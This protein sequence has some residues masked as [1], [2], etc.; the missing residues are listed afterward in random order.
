MKIKTIFFILIFVLNLFH[1]ACETSNHQPAF[2]VMAIAD[3]HLNHD[4]SDDVNRFR[5]LIDRLNTGEIP[6][7]ELLLISGDLVTSLPHENPDYYTDTPDNPASLFKSII[8]ELSIPYLYSLGNHDYYIGAPYE[9]IHEYSD[10]LKMEAIWKKV[11]DLDPPYQSMVYNGF[12][13]IA[14]N[15]IRGEQWDYFCFGKGLELCVGSFDEQQMDW[16]ETELSYRDP[17]IL[18]FHHPIYTDHMTVWTIAFEQFMVEENQQIYSLLD[19]YK[20]IV[21][22]IFVG[23]GHLWAKDTLYETIQVYETG[24]YQAD[25]DISNPNDYHIITC[26]PNTGTIKVERG[27]EDLPYNTSDID[28]PIFQ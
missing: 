21:K 14:L 15:S 3:P 4:G 28:N 17:T 2:K 12:R 1:I 26:D 11:M 8:G 18:I 10:V 16:L 23:H 24:A 13:F 7:I 5:S 6:D 9:N 22:G 27:T 20:D 19:E 25:F